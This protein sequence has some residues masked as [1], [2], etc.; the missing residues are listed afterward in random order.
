MI[1]AA[2]LVMLLLSALVIV[3]TRAP[4]STT[5]N[6]R[7][8]LVADIPRPPKKNGPSGLEPTTPKG[9]GKLVADVSR[10][11]VIIRQPAPATPTPGDAAESSG[12]RYGLRFHPD[13]NSFV[14]INDLRYDG[15]HPITLEAYVRPLGG[16]DRNA[17]ILSDGE[18]GGIELGVLREGGSFLTAHSRGRHE[19]VGSRRSQVG[20]RI[21]LAGVLAGRNL[22]VFVN[23]KRG[24]LPCHAG[25]V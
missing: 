16:Q 1:A 13:R 10:P 11:P 25:P 23:G 22:S 4:S 24:G 14:R 19:F 2:A 21:H 12:G 15:S 7:R 9:G 6:E 3:T 18:G 8:E 5:D 17:A 20:K